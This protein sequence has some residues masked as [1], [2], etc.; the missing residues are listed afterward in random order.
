M[1]DRE[2]DFRVKYNSFSSLSKWRGGDQVIDIAA[3]TIFY[4][5]GICVSGVG[6][7]ILVGCK[8]IVQV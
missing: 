6:D 3:K 7:L 2:I 8:N 5:A 1:Q 4:K